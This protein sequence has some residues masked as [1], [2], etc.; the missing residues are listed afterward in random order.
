MIGLNRSGLGHKVHRILSVNPALKGVPAENNIFLFEAKLTP[1]GYKQLLLNNI[2]AGNHFRN[3]MFYLH[4]SIHFD[5]VEVAVFIEKFKGTSTTIV[6]L[7]ACVDAAV[8]NRLP[9]IFRNSRRRRFFQYFLMT[10]LQR[11]ISIT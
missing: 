8:E 5:K 6:D 2:H 1:A 4:A 11:A 9:S 7:N 10:T 3:R